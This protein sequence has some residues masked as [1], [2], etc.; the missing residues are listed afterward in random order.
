[1]TPSDYLNVLQGM[2]AISVAFI[3]WLTMRTL[4]PWRIAMEGH[5]PAGL[6]QPLS[7]VAA[8]LRMLPLVFATGG[9]GRF[10]TLF[11]NEIITASGLGLTLAVTTLTVWHL[12]RAYRCVRRAIVK[13]AARDSSVH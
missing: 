10:V 1:M 12:Y 2:M 4:R 3:L 8:E 11:H 7:C 13:E 6:M 9:V 5:A